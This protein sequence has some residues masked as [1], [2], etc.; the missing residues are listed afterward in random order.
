MPV[1]LELEDNSQPRRKITTVN[2]RFKQIQS[3]FGWAAISIPLFGSLF[4]V[5][6]VP[7]TS[8]DPLAV[9]LL[10]GMYV[11]TTIGLE[12]GFHRYF[13]HRA[14]QTTATLKIILAVLGSMAAVGHIIHWVSHHR[15]HH[16]DS[17]RSRDPHS[18]HI[19]AEGQKLGLFHG[20]R[21]AHFGWF[22]NGEFPNVLIAKDLLRDPVLVRVNRLYLFWV[23]LGFAIPAVLGGVFLGTWL[24]VLQGILWGG[25]VRVFL[26]HH[27]FWSI[28]SLCHVFGSRPFD[29]GDRST[30][31][32]WLA[33]PTMG[34]SWHNNHH[35][36]PYSA[37]V[38]LEWW[39]IDP[40]GWVIRALQ[41]VGLVWD[42]K[43]PSTTAIE[44]KK[45][46]A[47]PSARGNYNEDR[48]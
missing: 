26:V 5:G 22:I 32:V 11:L 24:G 42:V 4:A 13:S 6:L 19:N 39:Q 31:N 36:F 16:Q 15:S 47:T 41:T 18:P 29:T 20:L 34:E 1:Q 7:Y 8:I 40:S 43:A 2:S 27:A 44:L 3:N 25:F 17:D 35:A 14:F 10:V 12:I 33:I 21:H 30:N 37:I 23:F 9:V 38:G 45:A 46:K 48:Y 28:N